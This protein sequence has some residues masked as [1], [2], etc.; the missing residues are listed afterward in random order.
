MNFIKS[1]LC[2]INL[3]FQDLSLSYQKMPCFY[4]KCVFTI[5][6]VFILCIFVA[7]FLKIGTV[8]IATPLIEIKVALIEIKFACNRYFTSISTGNVCYSSFFLTTALKF[9]SEVNEAL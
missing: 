2:A 6:S 3:F 5:F 8:P 9:T 1:R 7:T 4:M